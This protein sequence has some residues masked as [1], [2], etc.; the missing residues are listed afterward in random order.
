MITIALLIGAT[1]GFVG[2]TIVDRGRD[3]YFLQR[4]ALLSTLVVL[5]ATAFFDKMAGY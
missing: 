3:R 1:V 2:L 4:L 5:S